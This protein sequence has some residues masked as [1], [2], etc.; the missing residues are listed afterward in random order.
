MKAGTFSRNASASQTEEDFKKTFRKFK[1]L[2]EER[3]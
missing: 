1:S 3:Y 2:Y